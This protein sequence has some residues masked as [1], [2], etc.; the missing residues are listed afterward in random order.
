[1]LNKGKIYEHNKSL[2]LTLSY[3]E[4]SMLRKLETFMLSR[5]ET[6]MLS[7]VEASKGPMDSNCY[8][9]VI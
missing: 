1:M 7:R 4:G 5:V 8:A 3:V 2:Q 6:F 9:V